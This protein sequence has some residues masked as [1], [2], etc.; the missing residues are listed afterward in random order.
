MIENISDPQ[1]YQIDK[2]VLCYLKSLQIYTLFNLDNITEKDENNG[3][4][5]RK[6][7]IGPSGSGK[8]SYLLFLIQKD[9]DIIDKIYMLKI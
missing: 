7:I 4:P 9:N 2:A 6:L 1:S 3:W 8:T 5:H